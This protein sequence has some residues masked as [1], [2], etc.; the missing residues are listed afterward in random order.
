M[1]EYRFTT[2]EGPLL[3]VEAG[4]EVLVFEKKQPRGSW[5]VAKVIEHLKV[6]RSDLVLAPIQSSKA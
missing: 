5:T 1:T 4:E 6:T 3:I 2:T